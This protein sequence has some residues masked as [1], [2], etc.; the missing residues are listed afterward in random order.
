MPTLRPFR[1][2]DERDVINLFSFS[3]S[4][5]TN[6]GTLVKIVGS[7]FLPTDQDSLEMLGNVGAGYNNTVSQRYGTPYKVAVAGTGDAVVG[8]M[9]FD[10]K[11]TDENGEL[12]KF[13][14]RKAAEME[15]VLSG[16]VVPL[17]TRGTFMYSGFTGSVTAGASLYVGDNG[18][19]DS[20]QRNGAVKV[21]QA[22][23]AK[24]SL[25]YVTVKLDI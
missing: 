8:M 2:Y 24:D 16:Q 20:T 23:S 17:V 14:P 19:I 18:L 12:L 21:G 9:L 22:L 6:K 3:G 1:D 4:I 15:A 25:G 10:V 5:P 7:G 11:E 13:N